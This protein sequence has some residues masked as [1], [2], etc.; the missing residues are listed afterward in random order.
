MR[1]FP[2]WMR[3]SL[4]L[5]LTALLLSQA[6][7][8][9]VAQTPP[10]TLAAWQAAAGGSMAFEVASVRQIDP[11]MP[12]PGNRFEINAQDDFAPTNGVFR[13]NARLMMYLIFAYKITDTSQYDALAAQL[14][15]WAN[16]DQFVIEARA[17]GNPSKN[18]YRLMM[19]S[20]LADRFGLE[21]HVVDKVLPVY[22]LVQTKPG[23]LG[24]GLQP[25]P[26][27]APCVDRP[28]K[29]VTKPG[30]QPPAY[31]GAVQR[32]RPAHCICECWM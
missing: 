9:L 12:W 17:A 18:Q 2:G 20:L 13:A 22:A 3:S 32:W 10:A 5:A 30:E 14:P 27:N 21:L 15:K 26:D 8:V 7:W 31:C 4:L 24:P 19:Q 6:A 1:R 25:H 23:R 29:S 28:E 16:A 11:G